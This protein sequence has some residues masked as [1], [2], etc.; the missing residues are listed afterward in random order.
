MRPRNIL[1]LV[2]VLAI[3]IAV[4]FVMRPVE[5][6][7]IKPDPPERIWQFDMD[8]LEHIRIELPNQNMSESFLEHEDRQ[9]YFDDPSGPK[10]DPDRWG[11]G[12]PLILASPAAERSIAKDA[13]EEQLAIYGFTLPQMKMTLTNE[14]KE[15]VN[16]EIGDAVP[17]GSAYYIRLA[18][19]NDIY[20]IDG[21]WYEV[22]ER[23][24]LEPP[25]P[26]EEEE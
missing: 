20:V 17:D 21:I 24:V 5:E 13:T 12:I 26:P 10:V 25:Y 1:I 4:Y 14:D 23:L 6:P 19:S 7:P 15:F 8:E 22:L 2:A 9:W 11:G 3:T 18:D 16:I